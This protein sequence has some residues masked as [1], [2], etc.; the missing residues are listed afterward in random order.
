MTAPLRISAVDEA[1]EDSLGAHE[2]RAIA[3]AV[4]CRRKVAAALRECAMTMADILDRIPGRVALE[5]EGIESTMAVVEQYA[6]DLKFAVLTAT[7]N[8]WEARNDDR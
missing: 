5:Y 6:D 3:A 4:E 1:L 8:A 2:E 7:Q